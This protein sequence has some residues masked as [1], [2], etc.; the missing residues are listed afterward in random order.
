MLIDN[1]MMNNKFLNCLAGEK[2]L[3][4]RTKE[5]MFSLCVGSTGSNKEG[6][7]VSQLLVQ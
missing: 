6:P 5:E 4:A 2:L 3:L 7:V 1:G